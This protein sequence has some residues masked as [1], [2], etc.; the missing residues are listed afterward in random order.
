MEKKCVFC[1]KKPLDKNKEHILP[2]WL[3]KLTGNPK[4]IVK[5]GLDYINQKELFFSFDQL[6]AP[7]CKVCNTK[8]S[9]L[10]DEVKFIVEKLTNKSEISGNESIKLFD[11]LDKV[12]VGLWLNYYYLEKNKCQIDPHLSIDT[13]I[14]KKDRL[15][16]IHFLGN[17]STGLNAYGVETFLFQYNPSCFGLR[18]NNVLIVNMSNDFLISK[19]CGYPYCETLIL[20]ESGMLNVKNLMIQNNLS[21]IIEDI[22]LHKGSLTLMQPIHTEYINH[23]PVAVKRDID[24]LD[25]D[26]GIGKLFRVLSNRLVIIEDFNAKLSFETINDSGICR[27]KDLIISLYKAQMSI[28]KRIRHSSSGIDDGVKINEA[29][30]N[31]IEKD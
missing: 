13:R 7:S 24:F 8:Y 26:K 21:A 1:G 5:I 14:G 30:I 4:R 20:S 11:W 6:T 9:S 17:N 31:L 2:E 28:L 27:V 16:Q 15:L 25:V 10:E 3:L 12:R 22:N 18:I 29:I 23:Y 19:N